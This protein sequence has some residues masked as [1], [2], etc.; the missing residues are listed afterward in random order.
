[1]FSLRDDE[2]AAAAQDANRFRLDQRLVRQRIGRVDIDEATLGLRHDLLGDD[3]AVAILK[4]SVVGSGDQFG[5]IVAG[6]DLTNVVD[7]DD[8]EIGH[9]QTPIAASWQAW[10][11]AA[12]TPGCFMMV[13]MT[14][15]RIPASSTSEA[16][17]RSA[18]SITSVAARSR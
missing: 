11:S 4:V 9:G 1:M 5:E 10:A 18:S 13:G 16:R 7:G 14:I 12:A 15:G 8:L 6:A 17:S 2:F 3:K